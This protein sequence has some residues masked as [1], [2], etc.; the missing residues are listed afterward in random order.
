MYFHTSLCV[1]ISFIWFSSL[2]LF[3]FFSLYISVCIFFSLPGICFCRSCS[4]SILSLRL[5]IFHLVFGFSF[6]IPSLLFPISC[7]SFSYSSVEVLSPEH[8]FFPVLLHCV[9][10]PSCCCLHLFAGNCYYFPPL[11]AYMNVSFPASFFFPPFLSLFFNPQFHPYYY[12]P[13]S[14]SLFLFLFAHCPS[15]LYSFGSS[16]SIFFPAP[17]LNPIF[18]QTHYL[19]LS[20]VVPKFFPFFA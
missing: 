4:S 1:L 11:V 8:A 3:C 20:Y 15:H 16:F 7:L 6:P 5:C 14:S 13:Y 12:S 10:D 19:G 2:S 18:H 9:F 17:F